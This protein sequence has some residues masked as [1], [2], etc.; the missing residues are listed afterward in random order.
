[1]TAV[2]TNAQYQDGSGQPILRDSI[3]AFIDELGFSE[4][5]KTLDT[6]EL[7]LDVERYRIVRSRNFSPP[8]RSHQELIALYFSD[9]VGLALPT[10]PGG[11][12]GEL[13]SVIRAAGSYQRELTIGGRFVR[14]GI[15]RGDI[16]ADDKFITGRALIDAVELEERV[17]VVPRIL[18]DDACIALA[19]KESKDSAK[20]GNLSGSSLHRTYGSLLLRDGEQVICNYLATLFSE[21]CADF[22]IE[23]VLEN[24]RDFINQRLAHYRNNVNILAKYQWAG[25][26]HNYFVTQN[27]AKQ[28]AINNLNGGN[29]ASF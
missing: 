7:R 19:S 26:Y 16:Y 13:L 28:Y 3:A 24:H 20:A 10:D 23:I 15:T 2:N 8:N 29:F 9:N 5:V 1:M 4:R 21:E 12:G 14:G 22:Q 11:M 17:A 6:N 25:R 27:N 18:L